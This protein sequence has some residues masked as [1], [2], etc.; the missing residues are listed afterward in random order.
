ML[1]RSKGGSRKSLYPARRDVGGGWALITQDVLVGAD[2][3]MG[4]KMENMSAKPCLHSEECH[5]NEGPLAP[6]QTYL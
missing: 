6:M 5:D 4:S 3:H 2:S 1:F